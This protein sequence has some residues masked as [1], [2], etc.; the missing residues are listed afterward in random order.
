MASLMATTMLTVARAAARAATM[1]HMM[2]LY[3]ATP[4]ALSTAAKTAR[5]S[6]A[7]IKGLEKQPPPT[8]P[9]HQPVPVA[10][11]LAVSPFYSDLA[12]LRRAAE[13]RVAAFRA[14]LARETAER[15]RGMRE[16]STAI[17]ALDAK[18]K[19]PITLRELVYVT[20]QLD[21]TSA[22]DRRL[23]KKRAIAAWE[24]VQSAKRVPAEAAGMTATQVGECLRR[25]LPLQVRASKGPISNER[26]RADIAKI[27]DLEDEEERKQATKI[28]AICDA[29]KQVAEV[30]DSAAAPSPAVA[31]ALQ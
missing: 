30:G 13:E 10:A 8:M 22:T 11:H 15:S 31:P 26:V 25:G 3:R 28:V 27:P 7:G 21:G 19:V 24:R 6:V 2:A 1:P 18:I 14:N 20:L 29:I 9:A 4:S 16:L 12:S 5:A 23:V 17:R